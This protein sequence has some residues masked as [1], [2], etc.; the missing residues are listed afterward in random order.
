VILHALD[1]GGDGDA[2]V[3]LHPGV[4]DHRL[5]EPLLPL[6]GG[7]RVVAPDLR[8]FGRSRGPL[9]GFRQA[10]DV[11]ETIDS[12]GIRDAALV[13]GS[14]G[15]QI[16]VDCAARR[17][18]AFRRLVLLSAAAHDHDPSPELRAYGEREEELFEAG[19][20][21]AV[22]ELNVDMWVMRDSA[23]DL[24]RQVQRETIELQMAEGWPDEDEAVP[25]LTAIDAPTTV[26]V[27]ELD[28]ADFHT[29]A[30]RYAAA[31]TGARHVVIEGCGHLPAVEDPGAV[32]A[33]IA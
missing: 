5:W 26:A 8:G 27:G 1:T 19:D 16:A 15:G 10:E 24:V 9:T 29:I 28:H 4:G 11:L 18:G 14:Y 6:L 23:R 33:L 12:L 21:D 25:D 7:L 22:T 13:G 2:V 30:D 32:A 17:P 31:I 3:L 20:V